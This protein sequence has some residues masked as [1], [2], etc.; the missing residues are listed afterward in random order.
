MFKTP[1]MATVSYEVV[2]HTP[3]TSFSMKQRRPRQLSTDFNRTLS[4]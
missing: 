2:G 1:E 4:K 3:E